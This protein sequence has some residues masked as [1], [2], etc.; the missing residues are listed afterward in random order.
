VVWRVNVCAW[1]ATAPA[2]AREWRR[3][4]PRVITLSWNASQGW[5]RKF[6]DVNFLQ[7]N[8]RLANKSAPSSYF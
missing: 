8:L 3:K 7:G 4:A 2:N 1:P 6:P 5:T